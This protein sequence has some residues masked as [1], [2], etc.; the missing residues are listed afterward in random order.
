M[1]CDLCNSI[2][3]FFWHTS[4]RTHTFFKIENLLFVHSVKSYALKTVELLK[5][6]RFL[7]DVERGELQKNH[8]EMLKNVVQWYYIEITDVG[9]KLEAYSVHLNYMIE[10]A[11]KNQKPNYQFQDKDG[12]NYIVDFKTMD[13]YPE[14]D[15]TDT[16][17]VVRRDLIKGI[18][19]QFWQCLL[20]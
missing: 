9:R 18:L 1:N 13:E 10:Q 20:L 15:P 12:D 5:F 3:F 7:R 14:K 6:Y 4:Y 17:A 8:A 2:F 11:F 16:C 19:T